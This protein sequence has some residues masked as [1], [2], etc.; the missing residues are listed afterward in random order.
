MLRLHDLVDHAARVVPDREAVVC[1]E[2]RQT[3]ADLAERTRRLAS[4]LGERS[5][6]P[7]DRVAYWAANRAEFAEFL[8]GSSRRG[9]IAVPFDH[10]LTAEGAA[11]AIER[12][13]PRVVIA[14]AD[15]AAELSELEDRLRSAGV[16]ALLDLDGQ[17]GGSWE[18]Y[19]DALTAA[20]P[21]DRQVDVDLDA[22]A[23]IL[24]TSGTTG[25][26]KGAVHTHRDLVHTAAVMSLELGL[27]DSERTLHFLP[28]FS[29]CLEHLLPLTYV[30]ATHVVM[31]HFDARAVWE[32]IAAEEITHIDAV[33]TTLTRLME[34]APVPCPETLRLVSYASEPMPAALIRRLIDFA[35]STRFVQFYGMIEHLCLTT[36]G[37]AEQV[38]RVG[39]VGRPMLGARLR[40]VDGDGVAVRDGVPGE[41]VATSPTLMRGYW[42]DPDATSQVITDR[43]MRTGDLGHFDEDGYLV[44]DGRIKEVIKSGGMTVVPRETED[45]LREHA[46][47]LEA[48]VVGV[49]SA[50][51]GEEVQAFVVLREGAEEDE[52]GLL[53]HCHRLMAGYKCPKRI[54]FRADLPRTGIGKVSRRHLL[55]T[56][57]HDEACGLS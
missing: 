52:A 33:P 37:A 7:G 43:W 8:F 4:V 56:L 18:A 55:E 50:E 47:V 45:A 5:V 41:V 22:D 32:V 39:T 26:P 51:W 25:S 42:E 49:P 17:V 3:Y 14:S 21:L 2:R 48:A 15:R 23:L 57:D 44:L 16:V 31:E 30:R 12:C 54:R 9:A 35:P 28:L 1:G 27:G 40:I 38:S 13:R 6:A 36:L 53:A 24:F 29:S 11:R 10:W 19:D 46:D 34:V 20:E